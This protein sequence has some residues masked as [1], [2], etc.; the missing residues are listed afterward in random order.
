MRR[1]FRLFVL[2]LVLS[3]PITAFAGGPDEDPNGLSAPAPVEWTDALMRVF[4]VWL[5]I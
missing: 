2:I 1:L 5:G 4:V 3:A